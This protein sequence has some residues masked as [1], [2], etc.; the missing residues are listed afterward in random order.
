MISSNKNEKS[1]RTEEE[2]VFLGASS[3][4]EPPDSVYMTG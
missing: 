1:K 3:L 4:F 2:K